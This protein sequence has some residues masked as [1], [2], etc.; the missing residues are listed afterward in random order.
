[1]EKLVTAVVVVVV[2]GALAGANG[3]IAVQ[4][5]TVADVVVETARG[6]DHYAYE[7]WES[8]NVSAIAIACVL[9][10]TFYGGACWAYLATPFDEHELAAIAA[11]KR[12]VAALGGCAHVVSARVARVG[13]DLR[14]R[15]SRMATLRGRAFTADETKRLCK[16][17]SSVVIEQGPLAPEEPTHVEPKPKVVPTQPVPFDPAE[18]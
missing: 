9:T 4:T 12:E 13:W 1:M 7:A 2:I 15:T 14:P 16:G 11:T 10:A 8:H 3:C 17:T 5:H 6:H 18:P